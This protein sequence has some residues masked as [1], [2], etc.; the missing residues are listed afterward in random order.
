[1]SSNL[2]YETIEEVLLAIQT[3]VFGRDV[4]GAIHDGIAICYNDVTASET[5][6]NA[7][8]SAANDAATAA[9]TAKTA[10]NNAASAAN[11]AATNAD[12]ARTN[13]NNAASAAATAT[14]NANNAKDAANAAAT[15][16]NNAASAASTA[17]TNAA[18]ATGYFC[19]VYSSSSAY[20]VGDYCIQNGGLY[21]CTTA[22]ATGGEAWNSS[23]WTQTTVGAELQAIVPAALT[24]D[25]VAETTNLKYLHYDSSTQRFQVPDDLQATGL[26]IG[27]NNVGTMIGAKEDAGKITINGTEYIIQVGTASD[28]AAG[29]ITIVLE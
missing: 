10:A 12:T 21:R 9:D 24:A 14:T 19:G 29:Y 23:H 28:A 1:M 4:R 27:T 20:G 25:D 17:T 11:T 2:N 18:N 7:A 6:A 3:A 5:V 13:A 15:A 8:A 16:A 26:Y 22:I